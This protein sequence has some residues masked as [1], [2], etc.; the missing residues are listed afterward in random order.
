MSAYLF[1]Y[2]LAY[3]ASLW[4]LVPLLTNVAKLS[5]NTIGIIACTASAA[6]QY[7]CWTESKRR[8]HVTLRFIQ[9]TY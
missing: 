3:L 6:G 5:D 8:R 4:L 1:N 9:F 7:S 2:R